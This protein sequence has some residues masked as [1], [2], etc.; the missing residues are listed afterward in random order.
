M[1]EY[2]EH[3]KGNVGNEIG[4]KDSDQLLI[5]EQVLG[6]TGKISENIKYYKS[7]FEALTKLIL[8]IFLIFCFMI[9]LI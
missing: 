2:V 3:E 8:S 7:I 1:L 5:N 4:M 9:T 6:R